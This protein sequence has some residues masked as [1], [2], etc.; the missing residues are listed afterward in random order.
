MKH[1]IFGDDG[2]SIERVNEQIVEKRLRKTLE[3]ELAVEGLGRAKLTSLLLICD[4]K[5][6]FG[7]WNTVSNEALEKFGL[8]SRSDITQSRDVSHYL[9]ANRTL[10]KLKKTYGF[11]SL[12]DVDQFV[13]YALQEFQQTKEKSMV[14]QE[15]KA[16]SK[17]KIPLDLESLTHTKVQGLLVELGNMLGYD[18]YVADP[19]K[20]YGN[21]TLGGVVSLREVPTFTYPEVIEVAK[22]IDVIWFREKYPEFCF[23]VEHTTNIR[24]GLLRLYQISPLRGIAFFIIGPS[25]IHVKFEK[26][27]SRSPFKIIRDRYKFKSYK[28]LLEFI[29]VAETYYKL[30][31]DFLEMK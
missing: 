20:E 17:L 28:E 19:S 11:E 4:V 15:P 25:D 10:N 16:I 5:D 1:L 12:A 26:E 29:R 18:T 14:E 27:V 13:W 22:D 8:K 9:E 21:T 2:I 23:E 30:K 31:A 24:D 7:V 6:R 3:G